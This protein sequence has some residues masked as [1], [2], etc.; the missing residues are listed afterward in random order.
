MDPTGVLC[1][2]LCTRSCRPCILT[3]LWF[4]GT[5]MHLVTYCIQRLIGKR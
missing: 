3:L 4:E 2:H 5:G 1:A